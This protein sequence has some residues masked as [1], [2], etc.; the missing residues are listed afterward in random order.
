[1]NADAKRLAVCT[2]ACCTQGNEE[3]ML[4]IIPT[5]I[6][7]AT[8][9]YAA[10]VGMVV[11]VM[12]A[13]A[14]KKTLIDHAFVTRE[15]LLVAMFLNAALIR[16]LEIPGYITRISFAALLAMGTTAILLAIIREHVNYRPPSRVVNEDKLHE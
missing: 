13:T 14:R 4:L 10:L 6:L 7:T 9:I 1:M 8:L 15:F 5:N 12:M 2:H 16:F 3:T 11:A